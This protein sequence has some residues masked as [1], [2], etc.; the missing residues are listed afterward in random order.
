MIVAAPLRRAVDDAL[1]RAG[2]ALLRAQSPDGF[3]RDFDMPVGSSEAWTTALIGW[4]LA[5]G[6]GDASIRRAL[7]RAAIAVRGAWIPG[8]WGFNR[9]TGPDADSTAWAIRFLTI[10]DGP[11]NSAARHDLERYVDA[12]GRAHT[13][14]EPGTGAWGD[15]HPDVTATVGLALV[16]ANAARSTVGKTRDAVVRDVVARREPPAYWWASRTYALAWQLRFIAATGPI[17]PAV[18]DAATAALA[19]AET[20]ASAF[21]TAHA[22]MAHVQLG[23]GGDAPRELLETLLDAQEPSG[24]WWPAATLLLP[25]RTADDT[26]FPRGPHADFGPTTTALAAAALDAW[27][28]AAARAAFA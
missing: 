10:V 8:G 2:G 20:S 19:A 27:R 1:L 13:F 9:G 22:L 11:T 23:S 25:P 7:R 17:P 5:H 6:L 21:D 16:A 15:P 4:C 3:W 18:R 24:A 28:T 26:A 12:E 14:A